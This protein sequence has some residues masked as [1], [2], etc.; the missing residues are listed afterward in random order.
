VS[1][2]AYYFHR[3]R[4][5]RW[6]ALVAWIGLSA[7]AFTIALH[8]GLTWFEGSLAAA[9]ALAAM[10]PLGIWV[11]GLATAMAH[12]NLARYRDYHRRSH[13]V[14]DACARNPRPE[15]AWGTKLQHV[16][17]EYVALEQPPAHF[18]SH[19]DEAHRQEQAA[20]VLEYLRL[21]EGHATADGVREDLGEVPA[22]PARA[23]VGPAPGEAAPAPRE[24]PLQP[25][26]Q[27]LLEAAAP[28][29]DPV[30]VG[31][32]EDDGGNGRAQ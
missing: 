27:A 31:A 29:P 9:L 7:V 30:L 13:D 5:W 23:E 6:P 18:E 20:H 16:R 28:A 25:D 32:P 17:D 26:V 22:L 8:R 14:F 19:A 15:R 11:A 1:V 4:R 3:D 21:M 12:L 24:V 2:H 10:E